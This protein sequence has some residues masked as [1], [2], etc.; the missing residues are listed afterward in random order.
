MAPPSWTTTPAWTKTHSCWWRDVEL[1]RGF[2]RFAG[3]RLI[4][5]LDEEPRA[6]MADV[7]R[8]YP[9]G[10]GA[11]RPAVHQYCRSTRGGVGLRARRKAL[12]ERGQ[13]PGIV[14]LDANADAK[15]RN[16]RLVGPAKGVAGRAI[17]RKDR[18]PPV[19]SDH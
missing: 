13:K 15:A 5:R 9:A 16:H 18:K 14:G 2:K 6:R 12:A 11:R 19:W 8:L 1:D 3:A 10:I 17:Q 7:E 4:Q